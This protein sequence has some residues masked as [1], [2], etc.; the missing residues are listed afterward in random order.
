MS[1][2]KNKLDHE[3]DDSYYNETS[4]TGWGIIDGF[5]AAIRGLKKRRQKRKQAKINLKN[6][7]E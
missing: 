3:F 2:W 1:E 6:L 4:C 5:V 7:K